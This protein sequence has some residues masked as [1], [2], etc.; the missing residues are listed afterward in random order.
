MSEIQD[1]LR[2]NPLIIPESKSD[3]FAVLL[4]DNQGIR[5]E[6]I[7]HDTAFPL[8]FVCQKGWR[9]KEAFDGIIKQLNNLI[10]RERKLV[11]LYVLLGTCNM[12]KR[13]SISKRYFDKQ[14][15][16]H[17][18][19]TEWLRILQLDICKEC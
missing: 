9:S 17:G 12:T 13:I 2:I 16:K 18:D 19:T 10:T 11:V 14:Y 8:R 5:L 6:N 15:K 3:D 4:S 1:Y 7:C